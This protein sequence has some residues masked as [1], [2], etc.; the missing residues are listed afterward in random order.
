MILLYV[1][2]YHR[3]A[4]LQARQVF[5]RFVRIMGLHRLK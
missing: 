5:F 1:S 3:S 2:C 4:W